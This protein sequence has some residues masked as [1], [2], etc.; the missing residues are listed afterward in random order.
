MISADNT[1]IMAYMWLPNESDLESHHEHLIMTE[2]AL[3]ECCRNKKY[4]KLYK[5]P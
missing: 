2:S 3:V 4:T 1:A 5:T